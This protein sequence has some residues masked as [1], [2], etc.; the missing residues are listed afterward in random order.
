MYA[1]NRLSEE[2]RGG[3]AEFLAIA[4][5]NMRESMKDHMR[6]PCI[7]C[8]NEKLWGD[9]RQ[10]QSHLIR[11][12]F[13]TGYTY[14]TMHGETEPFDNAA[15]GEGG[16]E[17]EDEEEAENMFIPSPLGGETYDVDHNTLDSM[18][19]DV[20]PEEYNE[21]DYEKFTR[22]VSDSETPV[23]QGC[24]SKYT[25][26]STVLELMKLKASN[27][28]SDKSL[29]E[30]L[31]LLRDLLPE[32]NTIPRNTYEAKKVLCPLELEVRRIHACPNHCIL[33]YGDNADLDACPV[34]KAS[35]YKRKNNVLEGKKS[36]KGGPAKVVWYLPIIDRV[37]RVFANP[38]EAQL[39]RWH[40]S[41]RKRDGMLRHP[42]D[43]MQ[44][45]N[46][47]RLYP[48]QLEDM[49]NI[50][51]GLSTDGM[52]PFGDMSS[53]H[54]TWPVLLVNYNLPPWLCF[55]RKHI[56]LVLLVQGPKQPGNDIDVF[57]QPLVDDLQV[58]WNG[59][60]TWDAYGKEKFDLHALLF[61]TI[62]D[63]PALGNLSGQTVK[64]K[65]AC[66]ECME[67]TCSKWLKHSRKMVY[68]GHRRFLGRNH[69]YRFM[70]KAFNGKKERR[71]APRALSGEEVYEN[72]KDIK[73]VFGKKSKC[74]KS[75]DNPMWKKKSVFWQLDYWKHLDVRH[76]ID[77]MHVE[78]NVTDS[79]VGL[80]L[81]VKGKT[82]DGQ[83]ARKDMLEM[84][85]RPSLAGRIN[86]E[87]GKVYLPPACHT[88]SDEE[89]KSMLEC[90]ASIKVPTGYSSRFN[91]FVSDGEFKLSS[92]KS[93]DCHVMIT[94][95]LPVAIR[96]IMPIKVRHTIMRLCFFFDSIGQ[97]VID[98]DQ[99]DSL[100]E[101]I[102][103][104]LCHLEMYF[105]PSFFDIM[106]HLVVHLVKQTKACG[107]AFM[108]QMYPF[109]R[110]MGILKGYVRNRGHP[111]G[112]IIEGYT[113]EE[114]IE[115]CVDYMSETPS[116]GVPQSRHEGRLSGVGTIGKK[117]IKLNRAQYDQVHLLIMQHMV[118]AGPY[119]DEHI[120]KIRDENP[121]KT[122]SWITKEH[123]SKFNEWFKNRIRNNSEAVSETLKWLSHGPSWDV[124]T[125]Q[126]YD[127]NG[128]TFYTM[129]QDDKS[130]VQNSGIRID[131]FE[132]G[133]GFS[134]YYGRING[135]WEINYVKFQVPLFRCTWVNNLRG[136]VVLDKE[137]FTLVDFSK[138]G[139]KDE[140][141]VL[142]KQVIQVFYIRDPANKK[143]HVVRDGKR[144]IVGVENVVDEDDYNKTANAAQTLRIEEETSDDNILHARHDHDE[145]F[146]EPL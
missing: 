98:P 22:L 110:Y 140:P 59:V 89:R 97:K 145:G 123:T 63:W 39:V 146:F 114:V 106:V 124:R 58:L 33:Y 78:K 53:R 8:K 14:W 43:S 111:E 125:W 126:G 128:Y 70:T 11:R 72:V 144:S 74:K 113:T 94:Q 83:N 67:E 62:N 108:R 117:M 61:N 13:M 122:E 96:N 82:K 2:Y 71:P 44:W 119:F 93:H 92:M 87:T 26:L 137:G 18:L 86:E 20:E 100:Q 76:C 65:C 15:G 75:K 28:W 107:P 90:L 5:N 51:F 115:F 25:T 81:N 36:K 80:L 105:P 57:L 35:R 73:H 77:L 104:T 120:R 21:R 139:Y 32:E 143:L 64:G 118:E 1:K 69:P 46:V 85:I 54:S 68:M 129:S 30:L 131:A 116:I 130:T 109:E 50:R 138:V 31:D 41:E 4:E 17:D 135:I 10:V 88:L 132:D 142:A 101:D 91:K 103:K 12:G 7:D 52:N 23:Y 134:S 56:M 141:F 127:I 66:S 112:S 121:G 38:K 27:G 19:R 84:G 79:V 16:E 47:D 136:G 95:L 9:K 34:C 99:L 60:E 133:G 55:K 3:V 45:R 29:S 48:E 40:E 6:C 24:K 37:K 42:A 49:R 102:V